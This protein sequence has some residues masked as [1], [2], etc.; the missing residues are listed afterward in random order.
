VAAANFESGVQTILEWILC[1]VLY[2]LLYGTTA[3]LAR[4][5]LKAALDY[6]LSTSVPLHFQSLCRPLPKGAIG[7]QR[8]KP[9]HGDGSS[10]L[11]PGIWTSL[12]GDDVVVLPF[13]GQCF[14]IY[15]QTATAFVTLYL[16]T[17]F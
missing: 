16:E 11:I 9:L 3:S 10:A 12:L 7:I 17:T 6:G 2:S 13:V 1:N 15:F 5:Q 4:E 14:N 8:T